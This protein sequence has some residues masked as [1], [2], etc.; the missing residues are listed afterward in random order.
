MGTDATNQIDLSLIDERIIEAV[1]A[2][3]AEHRCG[4]TY[5]ELAE[6]VGRS[7]RTIEE[8]VQRLIRLRVLRR[9]RPRYTLCVP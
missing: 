1:R 6:I 9:H 4:P 7:A 5:E 2:Y 8:R 3:N